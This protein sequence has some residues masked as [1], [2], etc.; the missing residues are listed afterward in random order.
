MVL[1]VNSLPCSPRRRKAGVWTKQA[2]SQFIRCQ[3]RQENVATVTGADSPPANGVNAGRLQSPLPP[4]S[5][6][7]LGT[8]GTQSNKTRLPV[9]ALAA[10]S[11]V[12]S[13][14]S[15]CICSRWDEFWNESFFMMSMAWFGD[16]ADFGF[17]GLVWPGSMFAQNLNPGEG[18]HLP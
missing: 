7:G 8:G 11:R 17:A 16:V 10:S 1:F 5:P 3:F 9:S 14:E 13:S 12:R 6:S 15:S 18:R 4:I 2:L